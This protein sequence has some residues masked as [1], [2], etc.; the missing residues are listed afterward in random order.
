MAARRH[1]E[2]RHDDADHN[3]RHRRAVMIDGSR[4]CGGPLPPRSEADV[5][6]GEPDRRKLSRDKR[7]A[8]AVT[9]REQ[10]IPPRD[11]ARHEPARNHRSGG[12]SGGCR[13]IWFVSTASSQSRPT[14]GR[15]A[16]RKTPRSTPPSPVA[17]RRRVGLRARTSSAWG[18]RTR[19]LSV[20]KVMAA[21]AFAAVGGG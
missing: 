11:A 6:S 5:S 21:H 15:P 13:K 4:A 10:Q 19:P 8:P 18:P 12:S 14:P 7:H 9:W 1:D 20:T 2:Q 17:A 16:T 3:G